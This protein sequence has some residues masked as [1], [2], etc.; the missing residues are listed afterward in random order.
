[1]STQT[2]V[3]SVTLSD[4]T[5]WNRWDTAAYCY[6]T[7]AAGTNTITATGPAN[8]VLTTPQ[9]P[10]ILVPALTNTGATTLNITPSGGAALGAKNV[11]VNGVACVGGELIAGNPVL[12]VYDGTQYQAFGANAIAA[13]FSPTVT[14]VGG[15]GNTVPVYSTNTGRYTRI[16]NRVYVDIFLTGDGGAEGAGTGVL[17]IAIPITSGASFPAG[18]FLCGTALNSTTA[19][20]LVGSIGG[21][22]GVIS[23]SY[24]SSV[25]NIAS[26]TGA[27]QNN[28]TRSV[29]LNF[30]YE[31]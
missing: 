22:G 15:G 17:T 24:Y 29:R 1:M 26:M 4:A 12:L 6:L 5:E 11:F 25:T 13:T 23:L 16:G 2:Y 19:Y 28:A 14:L 27:D 18:T 30:F 21:G 3:N 10:V 8:M 7:G 9:H 31:V 20:L